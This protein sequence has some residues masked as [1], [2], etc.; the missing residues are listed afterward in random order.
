MLNVLANWKQTEYGAYLLQQMAGAGKAGMTEIVSTNLLAQLATVVNTFLAGNTSH[1]VVTADEKSAQLL[2]HNLSGV[3]GEEQVYLFPYLELLP[4]SVQGNNLEVIR[5]RIQVLTKLALGEKILVVT[6]GA[7]LTRKVAPL[8]HFTAGIRKV[9]VGDRLDLTQLPAQLVAMGYRREKKVEEAG[10]FCLRG[11]IL[12]I[13]PFVY[14]M[15]IRVEFFDDEVEAIHFFSVANQRMTTA[16]DEFLIC[17]ASELPVDKDAMI[18]A[19]DQLEKECLQTQAVLEKEGVG[20]KAKQLQGDLAPILE[21]LRQGLWQEGME[22]YGSHFYP[23]LEQILQYFPKETMVFLCQSQDIWQGLLQRESY[24]KEMLSDAMETGAALPSFLDNF[25]TPGQLMATLQKRRVTLFHD[26]PI[27]QQ[28]MAIYEDQMDGVRRFYS[29]VGKTFTDVSR[30]IPV[31]MGKIDL[32]QED[33]SFYQQQQY[34]VIVT[35]SSDIRLSKLRESFSQLEVDYPGKVSFASIRF[36]LSDCIGGVVNSQLKLVIF[37]EKELLGQ[38]ARAKKR[39]KFSMGEKIENFYDLT[40]GDYVVHVNHGIGKFV[41]VVRLQVGDVAKDYLYLQYAGN[42]KLYVPVDQVNLIQKYI[43]SDSAQPKLYKLGGTEWQRTRM[44]AQKGI[45]E[46][47]DKLLDLYS[48]RAME[49]GYAFSPDTNWQREFEDAFPYEET[50]HQLQAVAEIKKDMEAPKPMDRLLCGDVGYGKTEVALRAAFKAVMDNKQVAVLVPTTVLATQHFITFQDRFRDYG[51]KVEVLSRFTGTKKKKEILEGLQQGKIDVIIGTHRLFSKE[52]IFK[53][54]GLLVIDEEQRFGVAHKEKI[55]ELRKNI[56][57][58]TLSA[59]P[60]PRTLHM[61]MVGMRDMSILATPPEDRLPVQTFVVEWHPRLM[62]DAIIRELHRMGQVYYIHNRIEN[63]FE[64][65]AQI[66]QLAPEANIGVAHGQMPEKMLEEVMQDFMDGNIDILVSTTI[67]ESG[68][69]IPNVNTLIVS[70]ADNFGL[71]Q[72]YQLRGRVGRSK[73]QAFAYF[74][75]PR[76]KVLSDIARKRLAAI[77]DFTELGSGFKIAMRDMEIRGAGN[78]LGPQQHGHIAAVGF[79]L[80]CQMVEEEVQKKM[81]QREEGQVGAGEE[82]G[83]PLSVSGVQKKNTKNVLRKP[84][85]LELALDGYI[86]D[87]YMDDSQLKME[88]YKRMAQMANTVALEELKEEVA[89]RY[90]ALPR[91]VKNLFKIAEIKIQGEKIGVQS[92][93]QTAQRI[94]VA[95]GPAFALS[96]EQL[97]SLNTLMKKRL[98]YKTGSEEEFIIRMDTKDLPPEKILHYLEKLLQEI[99]RMSSAH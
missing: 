41:E 18:Q 51:V 69:D 5:Q 54:L 27:V 57:V 75:Y 72:L 7:S 8:A 97:L 35:A 89:E 33:L 76:G 84:L 50:D 15:A 43:A 58:L 13:Y 82:G 46:L 99:N 40:P 9:Q 95:F 21:S 30:D 79:D 56:D 65:A 47:A 2:Y 91:P 92:I 49:P 64:V 78:I 20:E 66:Q 62:K 1:L 38:E 16:L 37:T 73:R 36:V 55:K 23:A 34:E 31:Y 83:L 96:G 11:D 85:L 6:E 42:D 48:Q 71:A 32:L 53:D 29:G 63:I 77:R 24:E 74:T 67:V 4:F 80:Y 44:K 19:A 52:L 60:I 17:P 90:G 12:D 39:R 3:L 22:R 28:S 81:A 70:D 98:H 87:D 94:D 88:I 59:T 68:L 93:V 26:F 10:S 61:A 45:A 86:P 14:S 25:A